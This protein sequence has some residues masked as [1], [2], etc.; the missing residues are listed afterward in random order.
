MKKLYAGIIALMLAMNVYGQTSLTT[1][2]DFTGT[3]LNG[4][5]HNLFSYLDDDKFVVLFFIFT[6]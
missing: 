3:D 5:T 2:I 1:A 4:N 6:S